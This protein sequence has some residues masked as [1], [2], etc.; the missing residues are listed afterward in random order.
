MLMEIK[1]ELYEVDEGKK[2]VEG[3]MTRMMK[4]GGKRVMM[5]G[6]YVNMD[7]E[8]KLERMVEQ[9]EGRVEEVKTVIGGGFRERE[10]R[11]KDKG[12]D[13]IKERGWS[14]M[15]GNIKGDE[16]GNWTYTGEEA[17]KEKEYMEVGDTIESDHHLLVVAWKGGR[18]KGKDKGEG[19]RYRFTWSKRK[20]TIRIYHE[21]SKPDD[22]NQFLTEFIN[23]LKH[24]QDNGFNICSK[25]VK[26]RISK[27]LCDAPAKSF[28]L[29]TKGHTGFYS[30]TKC[31]QSGTFINNRLT[32][33][34]TNAELKTD[35]SFRNKSDEDFHKG[36]TLFENINMGL[37]SQVSL[38]GMHLVFLGPIVLRNMRNKNMYTHFMRYSNF[39]IHCISRTTITLQLI[40]YFIQKYSLL[41][42]PEFINHNVHGL[43]HLPAD[44]LLHG[45]LNTFTCFK[46]ENF[47]YQI[48]K[49]FKQ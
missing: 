30:C 28:I 12:G 7:L 35:T 25:N 9:M 46:Y 39:V 29:Y 38:D 22:T 5:V 41:Y 16:E 17:R 19:S 44:C 45:P 13:F 49:K 31:T 21:H 27:L 14:I 15:N 37:V 6:V 20:K 48:K 32:F 26:I 23:E 3:F 43:V 24:L 10:G 11:G 2:E 18:E 42:D 34:E 47:L 8:R 40:K 4:I 1:K 36:T 33:L